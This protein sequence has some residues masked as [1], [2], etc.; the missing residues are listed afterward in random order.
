MP[1]GG[2]DQ[3]CCD[4]CLGVASADRAGR[5]AR[6][7]LLRAAVIRRSDGP[8]GTVPPGGVAV[9][10]GDAGDATLARDGGAAR[11]AAAGP[12]PP[13]AAGFPHSDQLPRVVTGTVIDVSPQV[14]CIGD[15][16]GGERRFMLTADATAWRGGLLEPAAVEPGDHAVVRLLPG[17]RA[18]ADRIWANIGRV[19]GVIV[20]NGADGL[21]VD[22][23]RTR[24]QQHVVIPRR[25]AGRIQVRFHKLEPGY[26]IDVIG[27]RRG[28]ALEGLVPATPQPAYRFDEVPAP[29]LAS[30]RASGEISGSAT[31]H[32]PSG[33]PPGVLGVCYPAIDPSAGCAEEAAGLGTRGYARLPYLAIG[34][35][36]QIR[37]EC[38][39]SSC[40]LPV[41]GCAAI[42]RLF[43]D[44]C[45]TCGT[46][47]RGR[48][49]DLTL[50]SFVALGGELE[51]G[52]FNATI[53]ISR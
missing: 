39:G 33:E 1:D 19:T 41:T 48:V 13:P 53:T 50:A 47:R 30:A 20:A 5:I 35:V 17:R 2:L 16:A 11:L 46:S 26:L 51:R 36:L 29:P 21:V 3:P 23:G 18:V 10:Q 38:S 31:W 44:R 42:G 24:N 37:N 12:E 4:R 52:C 40:A 14:V 6:R 15:A 45:V 32:E 28:D 8:R 25:A 43:N 22:E 7:R 34:S 9:L 49:A 27:L